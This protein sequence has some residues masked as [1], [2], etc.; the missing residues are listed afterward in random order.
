MKKLLTL[1]FV[2]VFGGIVSLSAYKLFIEK[3]QIVAVE[4]ST[5]QPVV[6]PT[7]YGTTLTT[8]IAEYPSFVEAADKTVD[9]V[10]HVKNTAIV[11]S[12][13]S[14]EDLFFGRQQSKRAVFLV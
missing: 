2:S 6:L 14:L 13:M 7:N 4:S 1:V 8:N 11:S 5:E 12:P 9:A 10:V 3:E